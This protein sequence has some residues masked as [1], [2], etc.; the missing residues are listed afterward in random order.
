MTGDVES[1]LSSLCIDSLRRLSSSS[2]CCCNAKRSRS[3]VATEHLPHDGRCKE[4]DLL[5]DLLENVV[6]SD[7]LFEF[8]FEILLPKLDFSELCGDQSRFLSQKID[9]DR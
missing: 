5:I 9:V 4:N 1:Q 7:V 2:I 3:S 8:L 6:L